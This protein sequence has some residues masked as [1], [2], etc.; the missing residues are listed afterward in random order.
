MF[1]VVQKLKSL[2]KP[3]YK[4]LYGHGNL[5]ENVKRLKVEVDKVQADLDADPFNPNLCEEEAAYVQAFNDALIMEERFLKQKEKIE[6]LRVGDSNSVYFHKMVKSRVSRNR[7]DGMSNSDRVIVSG[8]QVVDAFVTHYEAFLGQEGNTSYLNINN[9][10]SKKLEPTVALDMVRN[11]TPK[12]VKDAIFSMGNDKSPRPD[13][14][15]AAFF[16]VAWDIVVEDVTKAIQEFF[17]NGNLLKELN[18]TIIALIHKVTSPSRIND[19]RPISCCNVL[20]KYIT[21][22]IANC[23]KVNLKALISP[24]QSAF[25]LG[26]IISKNILLTQELRHNYH[27]DRG[28]PRCAFKVDIQKA[29]DTVDWVFLKDVL[30][31]FG[32]HDRMIGWIMKCVSST[33]FYLSINGVL[34]GYFKG[35]R[36]LR[37]GDPLSPY[38]F[39]LIIEMLTLIL[40][41]RVRNS[42]VFT[43]HPYCSK[44]ELVNLCFADDLFFLLMEMLIRL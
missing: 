36:G 27:L 21:K 29:Y 14:F 41:R 34:H 15:I 19:Y 37:Q 26:R 9:L 44:L 42:E 8:D 31:G 33:S 32:F 5:Y 30:I 4:L 10:F 17:S 20:F 28:P 25:V 2:K 43:Y 13:G 6:W 1:C 12:E 16:K 39:T 35:K 3:I 38:L 11:V 40:Q 23:I 24:N 22:I 18:H 7:I